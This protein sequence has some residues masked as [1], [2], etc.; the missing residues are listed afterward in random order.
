MQLSHLLAAY[1]SDCLGQAA[2]TAAQRTSFHKRVLADFGDMP[3]DTMT[4]ERIR[5][6]RTYLLEEC[7]FTPCTIYRYLAALTAAFAFG[8]R[9][10]YLQH[11]PATGIRRPPLGE[12][13][14]RYLTADERPRL[15]AACQASRNPLLAAVVVLALATGG[16]KEE[17]RTLPW[18]AVDVEMGVIRFL[19]TKTHRARAVPLVGEAQMLLAG[20]WQ[21]RRGACPWVFPTWSGRGP[22]PIESP[23]QTAKKRA[24]LTDFHF[25]DLRHS[26]ASY[27]AMSG[28]SL[29]DIAEL[30]GHTT[31][32]Q[33]MRY[34]HLL[35]SHTRERVEVM[36]QKFLG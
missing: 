6:W 20:L 3:L 10:G 18:S 15:L 29:R 7:E 13:R 16:R 19:K 25:H 32:N 9:C 8:V 33:S 5:A 1:R 22:T 34:A 4:S 11:N 36:A 24:G 14:V 35:P 17:I 23:W 12:G 21:E 28:S 31:M 27:L 26:Y 2:T 30:L